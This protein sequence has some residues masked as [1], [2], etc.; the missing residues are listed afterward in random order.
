MAS[1]TARARARGTAWPPYRYIAAEVQ[2][3][4]LGLEDGV[5]PRELLAVHGWV[6]EAVRGEG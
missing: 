4:I 2:E 1:V 5:L 3:D 6:E